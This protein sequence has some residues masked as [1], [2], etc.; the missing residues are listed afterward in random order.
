MFLLKKLDSYTYVTEGE[1]LLG[2]EVRRSSTGRIVPELGNW[3]GTG[4]ND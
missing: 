2:E 4:S 3:L 1:R